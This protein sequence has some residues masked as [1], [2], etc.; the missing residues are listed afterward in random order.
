MAGKRDCEVMTED[1][2]WWAPGRGLLDRGTFNTIAVAFRDLLGG[3]MDMQVTNVIAE[4]DSVAVEASGRAPLRDGRIYANDYHFLVHLRDGRI[5]QVREHNNSLIPHL[6]FGDQLT[7]MPALP[8][9]RSTPRPHLRAKIAALRA[10]R[11]GPAFGW[12][13][14]SRASA[15]P[16]RRYCGSGP[17]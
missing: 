3:P 5:C 16:V 15:R 6:L 2:Q 17:Y 7:P 12:Q 1:V 4:G 14:T 8:P 10:S 13:R 9:L 11:A